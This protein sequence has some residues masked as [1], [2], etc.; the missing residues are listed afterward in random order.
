M[1]LFSNDYFDYWLHVPTVFIK[2][3]IHFELWIPSIKVLINVSEYDATTAG[4]I[5]SNNFQNYLFLQSYL[6][7]VRGQYISP[8]SQTRIQSLF[9]VNNRISELWRH[10][11][12]TLTE[13]PYR[14][15]LHYNIMLHGN[16]RHR[17]AFPTEWTKNYI[18]LHI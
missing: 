10:T 2:N 5:I 4:I 3:A 9:F 8:G 6:L 18:F 16:V 12:V 15:T 17:N 13:R 7:Q 11:P 14:L 1:I